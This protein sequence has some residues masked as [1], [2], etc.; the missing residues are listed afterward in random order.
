MI[1]VAIQAVLLGVL[2]FGRRTPAAPDPADP[3]RRC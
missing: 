2:S 3:L 1:W